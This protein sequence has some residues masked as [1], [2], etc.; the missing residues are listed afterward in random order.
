MIGLSK[1]AEMVIIMRAV[2]G[3]GSSIYRTDNFGIDHDAIKII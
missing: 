1:T 2:Q 3:I